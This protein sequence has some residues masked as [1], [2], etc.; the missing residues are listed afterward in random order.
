MM[1]PAQPAGLV[2]P[3]PFQLL[4]INIISGQGLHPQTRPM[5]TYAVVWIRPDRKLCTRV[6]SDNHTS[7]QWN[8]KFI[9]RVDESFLRSE[10]SAI[11]VEIYCIRWFRDTLIGTVRVL[12]ENLLPRKGYGGSSMKFTALQVRRPSGR[13]QGILNLGSAVLDGSICSVPI[14]AK[15]APAVDY[16]DLTGENFG[17]MRRTKSEFHL[18]EA[19]NRNDSD[20]DEDDEPEPKFMG[21]SSSF[22][23][24]ETVDESE[25]QFYPA[26]V[27]SS[28][29]KWSVPSSG[30]KE[31]LRQKLERWRAEFPSGHD[32]RRESLQEL[33]ACRTPVLEESSGG[34]RNGGEGGGPFSCFARGC[35]C[36]ISCGVKPGTRST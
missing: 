22:G 29:E 19:A 27:G 5:S 35:E 4:E 15:L 14:Y 10:T 31:E 30:G 26:E 7:P 34:G 28:V 6:D 32:F 36:S 8:D 11:M 21:R 9:F 1:K 20:S 23:G 2:A 33:S 12:V 17:L 16:R 3:E 24:T 13:P 25:V 18:D